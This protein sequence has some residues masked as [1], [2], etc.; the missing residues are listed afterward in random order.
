LREIFGEDG[1]GTIDWILGFW[2][3]LLKK[4]IESLSL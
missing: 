2:Y 4:P 1:Q 3:Q